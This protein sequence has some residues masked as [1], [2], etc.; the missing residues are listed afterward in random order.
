MTY[1]VVDSEPC[2]A[3]YLVFLDD[4]DFNPAT[5]TSYHTVKADAEAEALAIWNPS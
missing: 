3:G 1:I 2:D 4:E 5:H